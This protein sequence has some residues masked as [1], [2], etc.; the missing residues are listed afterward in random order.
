MNISASSLF[1]A[2]RKQIIERTIALRLPAIFQWPD[3]ADEGAL[4]AYGPSQTQIYRQVARMGAKLLRGAKPAD[5]PV[6]QPATFE[7][8][9]NLETAKAMGLTVPMS[10]LTRADRVI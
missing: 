3:N 8:V 2:N 9:I 4:I 6:E 1:N 10:L 7:L 5:L